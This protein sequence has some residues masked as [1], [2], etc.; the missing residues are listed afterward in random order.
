MRE[1]SMVELD[2]V[3]G[4]YAGYD[5]C[6]YNSEMGVN[7]PIEDHG[8]YV[9]AQAQAAANSLW[10]V[11]QVNSQLD[12][13][14]KSLGFSG[15]AEL[16][17]AISA[18]EAQRIAAP[19]QAE[20]CAID[21]LFANIINT[22]A[23]KAIE[24]QLISSSM[25]NGW[26]YAANYYGGDNYSSIYTSRLSDAVMINNWRLWGGAYGFADI[27]IHT[28][29]NAEPGLSVVGSQNDINTSNV[30]NT[31]VMAIDFTAQGGTE[32][33]CYNPSGQ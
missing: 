12:A 23:F 27:L 28:H 22:D 6:D 21:P 17:K 26:E 20:T 29:F 24:A 33:Y 9:E 4:G 18:S 1:L 5:S 31:P 19:G 3:A 14:A 11:A 16:Q 30:Y 13:L 2:A 10:Y 25:A 7:V 8:A 32:Y 15:A